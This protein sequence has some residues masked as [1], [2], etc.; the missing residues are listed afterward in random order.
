MGNGLRIM[1]YEQMKRSFVIFTNVLLDLFCNE[2]QFHCL[3][4]CSHTIFGESGDDL[5]PGFEVILLTSL[6]PCSH[7]YAIPP[8]SV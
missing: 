2:S 4:Y 8:N 1:G 6:T 3:E 7:S 5:L